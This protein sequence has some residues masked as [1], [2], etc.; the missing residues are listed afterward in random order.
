MTAVDGDVREGSSWLEN[1]LGLQQTGTIRR[2]IQDMFSLYTRGTVLLVF[3]LSGLLQ[4]V[5]EK[6][7]GL[8]PNHGKLQAV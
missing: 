1:M 8:A 4:I 6:A 5:V 7:Q 3:L 2:Q